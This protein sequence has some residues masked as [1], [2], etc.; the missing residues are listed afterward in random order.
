MVTPGQ[1]KVEPVG[2]LTNLIVIDQLLIAEID[3]IWLR[4]E[5]IE[6]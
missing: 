4:Q 6:S 3:E 5:L 1:K 2:P